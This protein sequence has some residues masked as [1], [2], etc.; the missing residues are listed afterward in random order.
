ML[1]KIFKKNESPTPPTPAPKQPVAPSP[2]QVAAQHADKAAWEGKLQTAMGDDAALLAIAKEAPLIDIKL[3][4]V[5]A[6]VSEDALKRAEK[7]FRDHDRRVHRIAKQRHETLI[8]RRLASVAAAKLIESASVL[9][10]ETSIPANRLVELDRAWGALDAKLLDEKQIAGY[11]ALWTKLSALTRERGEQQLQAKRWLAEAEPAKALLLALC[12]DIAKGTQERSQFAYTR[13]IVDAVIASAPT[14]PASASAPQIETKSAELQHA[15]QLADVVDMRLA[16]LEEF[17]QP[18]ALAQV[19]I[20]SEVAP[21]PTEPAVSPESTESTAAPETTPSTEITSATEAVAPPKPPSPSARW[22]ALPPVADSQIASI[23]DARFTQWQSEKSEARQARTVE[24]RQHAKEE[25][26]AAKQARNEALSIVVSGLV[27]RAENAL[28]G[29]HLAE[30]TKYLTAIDEACNNAK[31]AAL[32]KPL[33]TRLEMVQA[34]TARLKGWQHWGGGRVRDD[35]VVEAEALAKSST[36]EKVAI[37]QH[38]DA[39]E[40]LRNRWKELDKLAAATSRPLWQR[41]EAALK[42]AYVPVAAHLAKLKAARQ[43][44]LAAR[45]ALLDALDAAAPAESVAPTETNA[46]PIPA[47]ALDLRQ[48]AKTLENFQTEWRKCGPVEHTVPH[49]AQAAL[50]ARMKASLARLETPLTDARRVAQLER[51]KLIAR[52]KALAADTR[53]RE[54]ITKV[55]ELQTEWQAHAK[56]LPLMRQVENALWTEFKTA[57]DAVFTQRDAAHA[58]RDADFK[59]NQVAREELIAKLAGLN[60]DTPP[61]EI[62]RTVSDVDSA[63]RKC[64]EAPRAEAA[65]LDA[66][67]RAVRDAAQQYIAGSAKRGWQGTCDALDAKRA[68][69]IEVESAAVPDDVSARWAA[70]A[71][72]PPVWEKALSARLAAADIKDDA[73]VDEE[74][75]E[76]RLEAAAMLILRLEAALD[77]ES[78]SAFQAARRDLKLRAMKAAIEA[79]QSVTVTNADIERLI[80]EV[81]AE[82]RLDATSTGRINNILAALRNKPLR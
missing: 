79:R 68:I 36:A 20:R 6:L 18:V 63:W 71:P 62:K 60:A 41:F 75:E 66:K 37:K 74:L 47:P 1:S 49:K 38:A 16:L 61:A 27:E 8:N 35:L 44:N 17:Q 69:C 7:E 76:E 50:A 45:N 10:H 3:A 4:A 43:E 72:L 67:F 33:Q 31:G 22:R 13:A 73:E 40:N 51:E 19:E 21:S 23:L 28:V 65:R 70:I 78:P 34:E 53:N 14:A 82:P 15:L 80:G 59:A 52:A 58:A 54:V 29:G 12:G 55:R 77:L 9:M 46:D 24:A 2:A 81:V 11:Q 56:S 42:T 5:E 32:N 48:L 57:T 64:G 26:S 30:T 39:I 25:S